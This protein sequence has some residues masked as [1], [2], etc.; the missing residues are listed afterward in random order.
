MKTPSPAMPWKL[1]K[2]RGTFVPFNLN[3]KPR[4]PGIDYYPVDSDPHVTPAQVAKVLRDA[5]G[6]GMSLEC[7]IY[8]VSV[9]G[10]LVTVLHRSKPK[11]F[12]FDTHEYWFTATPSP[13]MYEGGGW[14]HAKSDNLRDASSAIVANI[15][16]L[17]TSKGVM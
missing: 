17:A 14:T 2:E 1:P 13:F 3:A 7:V 9:Y 5:L 8:R 16:N 12:F 11:W 15:R 4:T 10:H 6:T